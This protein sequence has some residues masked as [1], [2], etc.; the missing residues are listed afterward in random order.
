MKKYKNRIILGL[1]IVFVLTLVYW[2]G[3]DSPSLHGWKPESYDS[4]VSTA[5]ND[6]DTT[7]QITAVTPENTP[8]AGEEGIPTETSPTTTPPVGE[9]TPPSALPTGQPE[10]KPSA[11]AEAVQSEAVPEA[12]PSPVEP[13]NAV[14]TSDTLTCSLAV[15]CN[16]IKNNLSL[17][18]S[19][20]REL[21][22]ENGII[23]TN[24]AVTFYEGESVFNVLLREMKRSKIHI[25]FE[26]TPIYNSAYIEG[27]GNLY[28]FDCGEL[29]G[30]MYKVNGIFPNYGCSRYQLKNGDS[31]ELV[32]T[33]N[34][35][36]DVG[37]DYSAQKGS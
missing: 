17:L 4:A 2:W 29:S 21:V 7:M 5:I 8:I 32:Y 22:P 1:I 12:L 35:G 9:G 37:G 14:I 18:D 13:E 24:Q 30:W 33:C 28:E 6:S 16:T 23:Y 36:A 10:V 15:S 3:G 31:I 34:L 27:I 20:K 26:N 11:P 25:E 19:E